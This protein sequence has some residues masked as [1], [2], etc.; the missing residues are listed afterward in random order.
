MIWDVIVVGAGLA[1]LTC[2]RELSQS[3]YRVLVLE[4]SKGLGGRLATRRIDS[5]PVDHG[6]RYLQP[7][8]PQL[9]ALISE[10]QTQR[11]LVPWQPQTF[12]FQPG[13]PLIPQVLDN[14]VF[15]APAGITAVAKWLAQ[16]VD[17]QRQTRAVAIQPADTSTWQITAVSPADDTATML[18]RCIVLAMPAPQTADLLV[19]RATT[20]HYWPLHCQ[21]VRFSP[22]LAVMAKFDRRQPVGPSN[23]ALG[24]MV[25]GSENSKVAWAALDSSKPG[26]TG[27]VVVLQSSEAFAAQYLEADLT[28]AA[29]NLL[30]AAGPI[31]GQAARPLEWQI[32]RWRYAFASQ[33]AAS[34]PLALRLSDKADRPLYCCGDW[35]GGKDAGA[36]IASGAEAAKMIKGYAVIPT[37]Q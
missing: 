13:A 8:T 25:W 9:S 27:A 18:A 10:L 14:P 32:H 23:Q 21:T 11:H 20:A 3:G 29:Q 12:L 2:A 28:T 19:A 5:V 17:I 35:C 26:R 6:C 16:E 34:P 31:L 37:A 15:T 36:A 30:E 7:T 1:G 4:K 22:C 33:P 24:W